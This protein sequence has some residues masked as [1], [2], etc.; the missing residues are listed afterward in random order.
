MKDTAGTAGRGHSLQLNEPG[1]DPEFMLKEL[2]YARQGIYFYTEHFETQATYYLGGLA[3]M[4]SAGA[5]ILTIAQSSLQQVA[6]LLIC[7]AAWIYSTI[8]FVRLCATRTAVVMK[9]AHERR[10]QEY[11][12]TQSPGLKTYG[13]VGSVDMDKYAYRR[14]TLLM[15]GLLGFFAAL[16]GLLAC[17]SGALLALSELGF[18]IN[19]SYRVWLAGFVGL[20]AFF[21][22]LSVCYRALKYQRRLAK[23]HI[24]HYLGRL[25]TD[26]AREKA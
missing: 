12:Y 3:A 10:A 6:L 21:V 14:P 26:K 20:L 1:C 23:V 24:D 11:F 9:L 17:T 2:E 4:A 16:L 5:V 7:G 18:P 15:F 13:T 19:S 25:V 22:T 8:V